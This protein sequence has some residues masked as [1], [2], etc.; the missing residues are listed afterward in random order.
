MS[1]V[2]ENVSDQ[3]LC[4]INLKGLKQQFANFVI[5]Y[6]YK[7]EPKFAVVLKR[8]LFN[9][10]RTAPWKVRVSSIKFRVQ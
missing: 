5:P 9:F 8:D 2:N 10:D 6:K 1:E 4:S 3:M 7:H